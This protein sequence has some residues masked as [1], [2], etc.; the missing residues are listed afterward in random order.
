MD[1]KLEFGQYL[2]ENILE[3]ILLAVLRLEET[4][5]AMQELRIHGKT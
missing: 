3:S 4:R 5:V 2:P 1:W